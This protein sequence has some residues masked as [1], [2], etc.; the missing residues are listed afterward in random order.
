[1]TT[2]TADAWARAS[3]IRAAIDKMPF[4]AGLADGSLTA[5]RF[6]YYLAQDA[7][8]LNTYARVLA[9]CA[10]QSPGAEQLTF[11]ATGAQRAIA[12]EEA[13]HRTHLHGTAVIEPSPT[14]VA[15]ASYLL[16]LASSGS[17]A[18]LVAGVLPCFWIYQDVGARLLSS[19]SGRIDHPYADWIAT[20]ADPAFATVTT[21]A[22]VITDMLAADAPQALV[23]RMHAAFKTAFRF[24]FLF[25][26]A[27][28]RREQWPV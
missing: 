19:A 4:V 26:D 20:Y 28:W 6:L 21:Q 7:H 3:P 2:F 27:A 17:Y 14:C 11:W 15:Y 24:E 18:T 8:Y 1:M 9:A 25:W 13:L 23:E 10:T 16:S 5:D 22:K 12:V